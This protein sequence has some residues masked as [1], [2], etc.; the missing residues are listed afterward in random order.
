L[1]GRRDGAEHNINRTN[2][3]ANATSVI[4]PVDASQFFM[5]EERNQVEKIRQ[6]FEQEF[7][8]FSDLSAD[9]LSL[10]DAENLQKALGELKI[11]HTG[12]KS[13]LA[14][15]KKLIGRVAPEER[16]AFGQFV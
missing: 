2:R 16:G 3:N 7:G 14:S 1:S 15:S 13:E 5:S 12:K 6:A 8:R 4:Q 9:K 10:A 11:K